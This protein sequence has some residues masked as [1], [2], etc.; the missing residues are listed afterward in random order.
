MNTLRQ[1]LEDYLA[2]RQAMGFKVRDAALL[3]A[4]IHRVPRTAR[5]YL[6][7]P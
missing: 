5:G 1:A 3:A 6:H 2:L 4:A 7:H